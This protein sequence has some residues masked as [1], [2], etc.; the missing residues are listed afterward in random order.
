M[1]RQSRAVND[2]QTVVKKYL[3]SFQTASPWDRWTIINGYPS[4]EIHELQ[5][6]LIFIMPPRYLPDGVRQQGGNIEL[7]RWVLR[8]GVWDSRMSGGVEEIG[9]AQSQI[10]YVFRNKESVKDATFDITTDAAYTATTFQAQGLRIEKIE[11]PFEI[12]KNVDTNEF[13]Y[14]F[15]LY[16][17]G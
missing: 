4:T 5:S 12:I 11:G 7:A 8:I 9:I 3:E 15:D 17:K 10:L 16:L 1:I 6:V 14:E 2:I 13:R